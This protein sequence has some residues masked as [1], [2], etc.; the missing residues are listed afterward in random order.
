MDIDAF[1]AAHRDQWDRLDALASRRRLSGAEADE[2]VSLYRR[3]A[4]H[5]SQVRTSAPDPQLVAELSTRLAR[6]RARVTGTRESRAS[7]LGRFLTRTVPA[8]LYRV[9]W[10]TLGVTAATLLVAVVVGVWTLHSPEAMAALGSP[11]ELDAY[12]QHAFEAYYSTYSAQD[13][14]GQVWT[15]NARVAA[16]CVAGGVTGALPAWVLWANAVNLGQAGAVMA[17]HDSL[18]LFLELI[19]PHGLLELTCVFIAGGAGLRLFWTLL[20]PGQ[21]SR[22]R[23]LA[24]EGRTLI[25]V[26]VALTAALAVSGVIEAFVT[27]APVPWALKIAVGALALAA[28]WTYTI[29]LGRRAVVGGESGDLDEEEAGAVLPEAA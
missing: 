15:N 7:D 13:F 6:A 4:H 21:R 24:E 19:S 14:A 28:L 2:L 5:L 26:A 16:L 17:D 10:W 27:P 25:T 20:V 8:A 23:A 22:G 3:T 12:A 11:S 18:G 9:R 29:V 1:S